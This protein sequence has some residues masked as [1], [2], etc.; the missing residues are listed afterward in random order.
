MDK[1]TDARRVLS[2]SDVYLKHGWI[3]LVLRSQ[4]DIQKNVVMA[5]ARSAERA[6][7]QSHPHYSGPG[8]R[9]GVDTLVTT[10][11]KLLERRL[12]AAVP[13]ITTVILNSIRACE[14][15]LR[16]IG[17]DPPSDR[18][19]RLHAV[20]TLVEAVEKAFAGMLESGRGGERVRAVF[21]RS[22]PAAV[23]AQPFNSLLRRVSS[24]PLPTMAALAADLAL[25]FAAAT[26]RSL[27][28]INEV[29]NAADG[30]QPHLLAPELGVRRLVK[31]AVQ[32]LRKPTDAVADGEKRAPSRSKRDNAP[33][34]FN[35][36]ASHTHDAHA[37]IPTPE[38]RD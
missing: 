18:G 1:G 3:G 13:R 4:A 15:E 11:Q 21:E 25:T 35:A 31:D 7:F 8:M 12:R 26:A 33:P 14:G 27:K 37:L 29:I 22:Y 23:N 16:Q 17:G 10:L 2:N 28:S 32:M 36:S 30:I 9:T 5:D 34:I 19:G 20:L 24:L 38:R 6:F